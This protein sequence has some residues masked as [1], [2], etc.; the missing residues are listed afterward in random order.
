[1]FTFIRT[2]RAL[3]HKPV[4][5]DQIVR[6]PR[7]QGNDNV[8]YSAVIIFFVQ[9]TTSRIDNLTPLIHT[10]LCLMTTDTYLITPLIHTLQLL[11]SWKWSTSHVAVAA[12]CLSCSFVP[13]VV[14][15]TPRCR[16]RVLRYLSSSMEAAPTPHER[17]MEP[18]NI[19]RQLSIR[20]EDCREGGGGGGS[21]GLLQPRH[22]RTSEPWSRR[23]FCGSFR[24][25]RKTVGR[26]GG[27]AGV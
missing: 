16:R 17:A 25:K 12:T 4:S 7:G 24:F 27:G 15:E 11:V 9:L 21:F 6:L 5:R 19:L 3:R 8:P 10:L 14:P 23:T 2:L 13:T 18:K 1:M 20:K 26:G 22:L